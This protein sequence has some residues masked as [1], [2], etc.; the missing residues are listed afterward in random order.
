MTDTIKLETVLKALFGDDIDAKAEVE[1]FHAQRKRECAETLQQANEIMQENHAT[2]NDIPSKVFRNVTL[3]T[4]IHQA[5]AFREEYQFMQ[6]MHN[7]GPK[8]SLMG[9]AI[10]FLAAWDCYQKIC[11]KFN[12]QPIFIGAQQKKF[13]ETLEWATSCLT[14]K[15]QTDLDEESKI[16]AH[17]VLHDQIKNFRNKETHTIQDAACVVAANAVKDI[18][19]QPKPYNVPQA[20][21]RIADLQ[22]Y[23]H[24]KNFPDLPHQLLMAT[25]PTIARNNLE[26]FDQVATEIDNLLNHTEETFG[27]KLNYIK[28]GKQEFSVFKWNGQ[29]DENQ[30]G[31]EYPKGTIWAEDKGEFPTLEEAQAIAEEGDEIEPYD[32]E[33]MWAIVDPD[34]NNPT[35]MIYPYKERA[36]VFLIG[37]LGKEKLPHWYAW[38]EL[39]NSKEVN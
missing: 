22:R 14:A 6:R 16:F 30:D 33:E 1:R 3:H 11:K 35:N 9:H 36:A 26:L 23:T 19:L 38:E 39:L 21:Q 4:L 31:N 10:R 15:Q 32:P 34:G 7:R 27:Y 28:S 17:M 8:D 13:D 25:I 29:M 20:E 12:E 37:I 18:L 5:Q 24:Y 2:M